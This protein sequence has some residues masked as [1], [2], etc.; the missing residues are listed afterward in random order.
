MGP[1]FS[2]I[3]PVYNVAPYL[4]RCVQSVKDQSFQDLEL[5]LVDDGSTDG[6]GEICDIIA[7]DYPVTRVIHKPNGGLA[8]ARNAGLEIARGKY[9]WWVDSDDWIEADALEILHRVAQEGQPEII[10]FNFYRV[11]EKSTPALS[12]APA[13]WYRETEREM[14]LEKALLTTGKFFLSAWSCLYSG[15]FLREKGLR[16]ASEREI[17]SEDYLFNLEALLQAREVRILAEPL[18]Y[19]ELRAGSLSQSYKR[20]LPG[21]YA[22]LVSRVREVFHRE[23][24]LAHWEEQ[25]CCFFAWHLVHGICIPNEYSCGAEHTLKQGRENIRSFLRSQEVRAAVKKCGRARFSRK[26]QAQLWAMECGLEPVFYW[27]Y[28]IK[29]K[30]RKGKK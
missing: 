7:Q 28:V 20:D 10:K 4:Y 24:L 13:G 27:L 5:I 21:K 12:N 26:Q 3:L 8:S 2:I 29:P 16:F 25:I 17:C 14:L 18:Y 11:E 23:G 19:Y 30:I 6:S 22:L 15:A 9:I 1:F